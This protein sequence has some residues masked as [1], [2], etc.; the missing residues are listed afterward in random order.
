MTLRD[1]FQTSLFCLLFGFILLG[2][3]DK[4]SFTLDK[5][6][7]RF[8]GFYSDYLLLSGVPGEKE[9]VAL[10]SPDYAECNDLL[11][12]HALTRESLNRKTEAY[13]QNPELWREVLLQV[14]ESLR[15]KSVT[16]Q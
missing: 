10:K 12:R 14:R 2:C 13:K 6:D 3:S 1:T 11:L 4:K 16:G 8:V 7:I 9:T 15:K 5:D